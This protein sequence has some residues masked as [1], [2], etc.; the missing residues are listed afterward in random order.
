MTWLKRSV[1]GVTLE[2]CIFYVLLGI[3]LGVVLG[4]LLSN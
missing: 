3:G 4:L 1:W 2:A